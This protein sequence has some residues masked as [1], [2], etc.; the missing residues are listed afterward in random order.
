[1]RSVDIVDPQILHLNERVVHAIWCGTVGPKIRVKAW[2]QHDSLVEAIGEERALKVRQA[3]KHLDG[4]LAEADVE[5]FVDASLFLDQAH[6]GCVI[7]QAHV[8]PGEFPVIVVVGG[9]ESLVPERVLGAAVV[10][11]PHI[12]ALVNEQKLEG[13]A[14][15][16]LHPPGP[17][18]VVSVLAK[19]AAL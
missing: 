3:V 2:C 4:S 19:D 12:V 16:L 5:Y 1:V 8:G 17:V 6:V 7:V 10:T 9:V 11:E 13:C 14:C 15:E 18:T